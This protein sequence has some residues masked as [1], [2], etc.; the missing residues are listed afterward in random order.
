MDFL[1]EEI[2]RAEEALA[3]RILHPA[4]DRP[5]YLRIEYYIDFQNNHDLKKI[6]CYQAASRWKVDPKE[7][8]KRSADRCPVYNTPLDYGLGFNTVLREA[9]GRKNDRFRPT[10]DHIKPKSEYPELQYDVSNM[11]IVSSRANTHKNDMENE[12]ELDAFYAGAKRTYFS[13]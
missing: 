12:A 2:A 11:I 13:K 10:V 3:N 9:A 7:L 4:F 8:Y 5:T 6:W 1:K